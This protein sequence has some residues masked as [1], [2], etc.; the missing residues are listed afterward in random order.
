MPV[1]SS[2]GVDKMVGPVTH[3]TWVTLKA[4]SFPRRAITGRTGPMK[5]KIRYVGLDVHKDSIAVAVADSGN[6]PAQLLRTLPN[7]FA[8][9]GKCLD[10]LGGSKQLAVC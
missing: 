5:V 3:A 4:G 8:A 6:A 9:L 1:R 10:Q 2:G 7:D